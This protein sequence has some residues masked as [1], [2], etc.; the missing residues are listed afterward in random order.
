[1][2]TCMRPPGGG[3]GYFHMYAY[4]VCAARETPIFSPKF[5][6]R[7]ISYLTIMTKQSGLEHYHFTFF[8]VPETIIFNISLISTHSPPP[9]AGSARTQSVRQRPGLAAG[10]SASQTRPGSSGDPH[11]HA[12]NGSSSVRSPAFSRSKRLE[13]V[14]EPRIFTL[15][16]GARSGARA[17]FSLCRGTYL[18]IFGVSTPPPPRV[19][20]LRS[21]FMCSSTC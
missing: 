9:T 1:M 20:G 19:T 4:W 8:A 16:R 14:P 12:Q 11:F 15:D 13:L 18:P 10:Q 7:S 5:P 21:L 2:W 6:F 3:G 17:D